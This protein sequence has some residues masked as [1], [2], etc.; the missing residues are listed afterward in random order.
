MRTNVFRGLKMGVS[1]IGDKND[2][3]DHQFTEQLQFFIINQAMAPRC[4]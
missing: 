4:D 1:E 2:Q 3:F